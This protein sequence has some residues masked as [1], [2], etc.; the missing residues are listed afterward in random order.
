MYQLIKYDPNR[1][2]QIV[3][4]ASV[5][6]P[7]VPAY[8]VGAVADRCK[9]YSL[10]E[11]DQHLSSGYIDPVAGPQPLHEMD[12]GVTD[13]GGSEFIL[14]GVPEGAWVYVN[15]VRHETGPWVFN[16]V[17]GRKTVLEVKKNRYKA[18]RKAIMHP[19]ADLEY[20]IDA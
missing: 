7:N 2:N 13:T 17:D 3:G 16:H 4:K 11:G 20:R 12:I 14:T 15:G 5:K 19:R 1:G 8:V 10:K 9:V 18:W 6:E